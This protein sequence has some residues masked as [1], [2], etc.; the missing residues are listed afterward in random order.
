[1][2]MQQAGQQKNKYLYLLS[3]ISDVVS[4]ALADKD[5][6]D[7][8]LWEMGNAIDLDACWIQKFNA[9]TNSLVLVA[10]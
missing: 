4:S 7:S 9:S 3:D 6:L 2:S 10:H 1:M 5:I 8:V